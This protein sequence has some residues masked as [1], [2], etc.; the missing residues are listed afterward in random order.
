MPR[1][2]IGFTLLTLIAAGAITAQ[3][4]IST[5]AGMVFYVE[6]HVLVDGGGP[7]AGGTVTHQ[8]AQ[9]DVLF[10]ERGRAEILLNPATVLCLSDASRIRM[11][12]AELTDARVSIGG[13]SAVVTIGRLA[14]FD[15]VEIGLG[16]AFVAL[17]KSGEYRFDASPPDGGPPALRVYSGRAEVSR[18]ADASKII[19]KQGQS[20]RLDVMELSRFD[21]GDADALEAW[22]QA[23]EIAEA[24]YRGS[25]GSALPPLPGPQP[26]SKF[27]SVGTL[28]GA[29]GAKTP[30]DLVRF[31]NEHVSFDWEAMGTVSAAAG[32]LL[33]DCSQLPR[34]CSARLLDVPELG[35]AVVALRKKAAPPA[36]LR[37]R[38]RTLGGGT[39]EF[40]GA[41]GV[42]SNL[43]PD[44]RVSRRGNKTYL[45][46][47]RRGVT[48]SGIDLATED[49]IDLS[50][51]RFEPAISL[52]TNSRYS[53]QYRYETTASIVSWQTDPVESV[54]VEYRASADELARSKTAAATFVR[55]GDT[56]VLD[57]SRSTVPDRARWGQFDIDA[58][59]LLTDP[60]AQWSLPHTETASALAKPEDA[61]ALCGLS[62]K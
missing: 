36:F 4:V 26:H 34:E 53:A 52:V 49:W 40:A 17:T 60:P 45:A 15:R 24:E 54:Q 2:G 9:G 46:I 50:A 1:P 22:A 37:Y 38:H 44:Y 3:P 20:V 62:S 21:P 12:S 6:G 43:E 27:P 56:F 51:S 25:F 13:G 33:D 18:S 58:R 61:P 31:V 32:D 23:R 19:A 41:F 8:L 14:K 35:Q 59:R 10:T 48:D 47:S 39:W 5:K 11:D 7:L 30:A 28:F 55:Q 16:G 29:E 57:D 42:G